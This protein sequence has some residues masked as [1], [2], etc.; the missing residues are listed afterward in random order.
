LPR[1]KEADHAEF[2]DNVETYKIA[3][4]ARQFQIDEQDI[5]DDRFNGINPHVA[6]EF[7]QAA[8][9]LRPD[10]VYA[11]LLAN[12]NMRD[13]VALFHASHSNLNTSN[14]LAIAGLT[15]ARKAMMLQRE[16]GV[17][18][19]LL[20][21]FLIVPPALE[22]TALELSSSPLLITGS[23]V[24]RPAMNALASSGFT[25]VPEP[26]LENGVTDPATG[27]VHSGSA[28]T[29]FG[30]AMAGSGPTIEVGY[31]A[32]T[33]RAPQ[34]RSGMLDRGRWGMWFDIKH[35]IGAKALDWRT[36]QKNTA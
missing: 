24:V 27:T 13:G 14:A 26:R 7:G 9:R 30:A 33:G 34:L 4:Y 21:K 29:W 22:V 6:R 23:D 10:L 31:L 16:N 1:Q 17:N 2:A 3:R 8:A 35:D 5:I 25:I 18:L 20:L 32:G 28:T 36:L 11:L 12:A 19:G 15:A